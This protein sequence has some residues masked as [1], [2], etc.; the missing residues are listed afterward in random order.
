MTSVPQHDGQCISAPGEALLEI[1]MSNTFR[2]FLHKNRRSIGLVI[3][4]YTLVDTTGSTPGS[5][6][7]GQPSGNAETGVSS[8]HSCPR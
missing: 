8:S 7:F 1:T 3:L 2:H 6:H 5:W 4:S